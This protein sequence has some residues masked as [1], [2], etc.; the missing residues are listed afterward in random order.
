[1]IFTTTFPKKNSWVTKKNLPFSLPRLPRLPFRSEKPAC[2]ARRLISLWISGGKSSMQH[3]G[4]CYE[5][6]NLT[7]L[8]SWRSY[9]LMLIDI[10][11]MNDMGV[12][13]NRGKTTQIIHFNRVFHYKPSILGY[14]YFWKHP[15]LKWQESRTLNDNDIYLVVLRSFQ[16]F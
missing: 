7:N 2:S 8:E 3:S 5:G 9:Q 6:T 4:S 10:C 1:M 14:P 11:F 15:Y 13:K 12:S 16:R